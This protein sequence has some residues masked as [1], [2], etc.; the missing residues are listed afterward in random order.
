MKNEQKNIIIDASSQYFE[1]F[2]RILSSLELTNLISFLISM[3]VC[4][5]L[6]RFVLPVISIWHYHRITSDIFPMNMNIWSFAVL[7]ANMLPGVL[8]M[9]LFASI[10]PFLSIMIFSC[11]DR[12]NLKK[13]YWHSHPFLSPR[14]QEVQRAIIL[15]LS[16]HDE[17]KSLY[18]AHCLKYRKIPGEL[19]EKILSYYWI[20]MDDLDCF[21]KG[22]VPVI[23]EGSLQELKTLFSDSFR[24]EYIVISHQP[25]DKPGIVLFLNKELFILSFLFSTYVSILI[26]LWNL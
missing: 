5:G 22:Y 1:K 24:Q 19:I 6:T 25:H 11:I 17:N 20:K 14:I 18:I 16:G 4:L 10:V 8:I 2:I 21:Q 3:G 23:L 26:H 12:M 7:F 9:S 15:S 13:E